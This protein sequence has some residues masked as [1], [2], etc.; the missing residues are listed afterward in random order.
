Q[1]SRRVGGLRV[2]I[3]KFHLSQLRGG[4]LPAGCGY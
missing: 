1:C 4:L 3:A 2:L